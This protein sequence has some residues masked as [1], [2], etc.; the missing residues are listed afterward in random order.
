MRAVPGAGITPK[1]TRIFVFGQ[2]CGSLRN[3][4]Y[5]RSHTLCSQYTKSSPFF[6]REFCTKKIPS[7]VDG[8][9]K[10]TIIDL[11]CWLCYYKALQDGLASVVVPIDKLSILVTVVF[12][13]IVFL[14]K[15]SKKSA[16]GL[17]AIVIGTLVVLIP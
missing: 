4:N 17:A 12:S 7:S 8:F 15:L 10:T 1:A 11:G 6:Q 5:A 16:M 3:R 14:E 9:S 2:K 13:R